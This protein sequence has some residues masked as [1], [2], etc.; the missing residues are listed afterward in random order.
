M[1][2]FSFYPSFSS[3]APLPNLSSVSRHISH[4]QDPNP[5]L[6]TQGWNLR[7]E[8]GISF[9][10]WVF[11]LEVKICAWRLRGG[12]R[13]RRRRKTRRKFHYVKVTPLGPLLKRTDL[14]P[15][16]NNFRPKKQIL[17]KFG[18]IFCLTGPMWK[19]ISSRV[20]CNSTPCF[21]S[22]SIRQS[23]TIYFFGIY[24]VFGYT[25]PAQ[26]LH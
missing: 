18:K 23:V 11:N 24:G 3:S 21:I 8:D 15:N 20:L 10:T 22:T 12:G 2:I 13:G 4:P 16:R 14:K 26:M 19:N 5:S 9:I 25:A 7:L 6:E 17:C 1:E